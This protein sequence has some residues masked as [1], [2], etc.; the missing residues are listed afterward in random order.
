[1]RLD[2]ALIS[3]RGA[4]FPTR[5]CL[6]LRL[7]VEDPEASLSRREK[8][9]AFCSS[10]TPRYRVDA[11]GVTVDLGGLGRLHGEG[12]PAAEKLCAEAAR[13]FAV[14]SA[15]WGPSPLVARLASHR[16]GRWGRGSLLAVPGGSVAAFLESV[17]VAAL[18]L[19]E[20]R[21]G[22]GLRER[23]HLLGV[24]TLGDLQMVPLDLLQAV[25]GE[26]GRRL[27]QTAFGHEEWVA[28]EGSGESRPV[29]V[30]RARWRRPLDSPLALQALW[31][32]LALRGVAWAQSRSAGRYRWR[33]EALR[34][35]GPRQKSTRLADLPVDL[36][37]WVA[38]VETLWRPLSR[39]RT[40]LLEV[41]LFGGGVRAG[42]DGQMD[43]FQA[44][45]GSQDLARALGR[46]RRGPDPRLRTAGEI[47]LER[48]GVRWDSEEGPEGGGPVAG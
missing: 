13:H 18:P 40:G 27:H 16:A 35:G 41:A 1:M 36:E 29:L 33:L 47:L 19:A 11:R 21:Q 2:P 34:A 46:I 4:V 20:S 43:L 22:E 9:D 8:I 45:A 6:H 28:R 17:P 5:P 26:D 7:P 39:R 14:W 44:S 37:H 31:R 12:L 38:L 25:F 15:G 48:W 3:S 10:V 42:Q 24:R 23:L 30:T 32:G